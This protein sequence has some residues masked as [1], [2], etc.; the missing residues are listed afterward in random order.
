MLGLM[1]KIDSLARNTLEMIA[2][3]SGGN[4]NVMRNVHSVV[5][6]YNLSEKNE[7]AASVACL[8]HENGRLIKN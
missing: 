1:K 5:K 4:L 6:Y 3:K 8:L 7:I 2:A